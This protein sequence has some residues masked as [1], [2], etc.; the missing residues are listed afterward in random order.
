MGNPSG[1]FLSSLDAC[2]KA[3]DLLVTQQP[4]DLRNR[5]LPVAEIALGEEQPFSLPVFWQRSRPRYK[6][7]ERAYDG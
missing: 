5:Q 2:E 3:T 7:R 4:R 6:A 1:S